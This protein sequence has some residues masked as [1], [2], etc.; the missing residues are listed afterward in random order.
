MKDTR[1]TDAAIALTKYNI[2]PTYRKEQ[3][4]IYIVGLL[5]T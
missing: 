2:Q 3:M 4:N 5:D 1:P